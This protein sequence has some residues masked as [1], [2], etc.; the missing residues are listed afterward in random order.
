MGSVPDPSGHGH[1]GS[2]VWYAEGHGKRPIVRSG[3]TSPTG[4]TD[5][6]EVLHL[7]QRVKRVGGGYSEVPYSDA[8]LMD[9]AASE[10]RALYAGQGDSGAPSPAIEAPTMR[11][12]LSL[13]HI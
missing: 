6:A 8:E 12:V 10:L 9:V 2:S 5:L 3:F 13:I 11:L 7:P 1:P 4:A